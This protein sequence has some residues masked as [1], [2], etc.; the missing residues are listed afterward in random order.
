MA[1]YR[2]LFDGILA[3]AQTDTTPYP[4]LRALMLPKAQGSG[5]RATVAPLGLRR[6]EAALL[7]GGFTSDKVAVVD[8]DHLAEAIGKNTRVVGL[9]TGDPA[10]IGM[11]TTTMTAVAG[12]AGYPSVLFKRLVKAV[13]RASRRAG[14]S[15]R[16]VA[17]GPGAW[18]LLQARE[19]ASELG[20]HHVVTGYSEGNAPDLFHR[21]VDGV[22]V[23]EVSVGEGVSADAIPRI[24]GASTMGVIEISRGCG[25]GC[26]FCTIAGVPMQHLPRETILSDARVNLDAGGRHLCVISEDLFRYGAKGRNAEPEA[27]IGLLSSIR[28]LGGVGLIQP[29]H[30]NV[31]SLSQFDDAQLRAVRDLMTGDT[32]QQYPWINIGVETAS[33]H[34]LRAAGGGPK[35]GAWADEDWAAAC[36]EQLARLCRAGFFPMASLVVGMPGETSH[37]LQKTA[38]W[39]DTL[40]GLR[41]AVFPVVY[42]PVDGS[43]PPRL[44]QAHW[45]LIRACYRFNF[46]WVPAMFWDNQKAAGVPRTR[47]CLM[48]ALGRGQA[49]LWRLL[50]RWRLMRSRE[51]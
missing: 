48:Q 31:L 10:N 16:I 9:A 15:P 14:V 25:L 19:L 13:H 34:L 27:L 44:T 6:I 20:I 38:Q 51:V 2:I 46:R 41:L 49:M 37:D 5:T 3:C 17:G 50:F 24:R 28:E 42:A 21:L 47:R 36:T 11:S 22:E 7:D 39:L 30:G 29:D 23:P 12:G 1:G 43:L 32:G 4:L 40:R 45:H 18:Q 8:E 26:S 33:G 35:M